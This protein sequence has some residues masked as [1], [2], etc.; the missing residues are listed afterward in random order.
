MDS[1]A[2]LRLGAAS[3][4]IASMYRE[5]ANE[6]LAR[7]GDAPPGPSQPRSFRRSLGFSVVRVGL[8]IGGMA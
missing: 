4:R 5:A 8:R 2:Q 3:D 6:R 7:S 1:Y